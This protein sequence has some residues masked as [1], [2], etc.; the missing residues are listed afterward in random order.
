MGIN[1]WQHYDLDS[2]GV[3]VLNGDG[4]GWIHRAKTYLPFLNYRMLD[5]YHPQRNLLKGLGRSEFLSKVRG[6]IADY[7]KEKTIKL[8]NE[9]KSYRKNQ[10]DRKKVESL[11]NYILKHWENILDYRK[12][13]ISTPNIARGMGI[14]ESNVDYILAG[15][16][17]KQGISWSEE[18]AAYR[19]LKDISRDV[20]ESPV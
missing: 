5:S 9:A 7:D 6:A 13:D 19:F 10:K 3:T 2:D 4:A 20:P 18:G 11:K 8:L 1:I 15:R 14:I 12:K 17:K 16:L